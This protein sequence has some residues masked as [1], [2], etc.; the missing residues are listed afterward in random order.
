[1]ATQKA[2]RSFLTSEPLRAGEG[3]RTPDVQL[4]KI[5]NQK[6]KIPA[7]HRRNPRNPGPRAVALKPTFVTRCARMVTNEPILA[8]SW[9]SRGAV[10]LSQDE[11]YSNPVIKPAAVD[12]RC[13]RARVVI[14]WAALLARPY[15]A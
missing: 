11:I 7:K 3:I 1:M 8:I 9:C 12:L 14:A 6:P 5:T 10:E 15:A 13:E 4:G 2:R